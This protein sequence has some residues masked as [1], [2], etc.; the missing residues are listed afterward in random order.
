MA[1]ES[2]STFLLTLE[3]KLQHAFHTLDD[4]DQFSLQRGVPTPVIEEIMSC[5]PLSV[6]IPEEFGG[7]GGNVSEVLAVLATASYESL[8]LSLTFG[9]NLALFMRPLA[10][11]GHKETQ[12]PIFKRFLE[13]KSMGGLMMTEPEHGVDAL[14]MQTSFVENDGYYN[15]KGT[16]HWNGLT[17]WADFWLIVA[18]QQ[19][20]SGRLKRDI[21]FF[22]CD[23]S[24]SDQSITVEEMYDSLGLYF[25][26]YGINK[27]DV[28]IPKAQKLE[29]QG[30]GMNMMLDILHCSRL[31]FPGMAMGFLERMLKEGQKHCKERFIN[32][33]SLITYDHIQE[34]LAYIQAAFT[35]CSA[36]CIHV[37]KH[38]EIRSNLFA[39][40]LEANAVK[41]VITDL[42]QEASQSLL[43][44]F[45]AKGYR[46][47]HIVGRATVDSRPFQI[48]EGPN[49]V[50]YMQIA[51]AVLKLMK[52]SKEENLFKFLKGYYLTIQTS[53]ALRE[54]LDFRIDFQLPQRKLTDLG[55][56]LGRIISMEML[57]ELN[58]IGFREDLITNAFSVLEQEITTLLSN[59]HFA[60]NTS[61]IDEYEENSSWLHLVN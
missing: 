34:R 27:I 39:K 7:R 52:D 40:G 57:F 26:P 44:L 61:F 10:L 33:K 35:I 20:K 25:I 54:V 14:N 56:V 53:E 46:L 13:E 12:G 30:S 21:G 48:F 17:N 28:K 36:M 58:V 50:L 19:S 55:K 2:F 42:M 4:I 3:Q 51:E 41:S 15:L 16:K 9:I 38:L 59:Y 5:N 31:F 6:G 45:G 11:Y 29:P 32:G 8:A 18:R 60:K 43:Q 37:T 49:D 1:I 23:T 47:N 22:V 24:Q